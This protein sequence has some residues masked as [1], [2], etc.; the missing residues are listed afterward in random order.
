MAPDKVK[1]AEESVE[2]IACA[3]PASNSAAS[4]VFNNL[5]FILFPY[6]D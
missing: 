2:A 3:I 4:A 6:N 1:P 5:I